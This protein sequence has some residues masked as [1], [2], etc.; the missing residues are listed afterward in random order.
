MIIPQ[1]FDFEFA[2]QSFSDTQPENLHKNS[3]ESSKHIFLRK[4]LQILKEH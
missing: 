4:S 2:T 3:K 1:Y